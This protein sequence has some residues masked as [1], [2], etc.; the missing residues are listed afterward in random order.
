[1]SEKSSSPVSEAMSLIWAKSSPMHPLYCHLID[2]GWVSHE[3][4]NSSAFESVVPIFARASGIEE[5]QAVMW[6]SYFSAMHDIGKCDSR[7]QLYG[8]DSLAACVSGLGLPR[9]PSPCPKGFNHS[10]LSA[11]WMIDYLKDELGWH[12]K[13]AATVSVCLRGHHGDLRAEGP[14]CEPDF[15]REAWE[16]LRRETELAVRSVFHPDLRAPAFDDHSVVGIILLGIL[17][18]SDWVASNSE[19]FLIPE[20]SSDLEAYAKLSLS[21]AR[22][23]VRKLGFHI[24]EPV[25]FG[26]FFADVWPKLKEP[27]PIQTEIERLH[28]SGVLSQPGLVIIE[29]PMGEG[30]TEA[31]LYL[32]LQWIRSGN[33]GGLYVALP[34][35]ATS[36]QMYRR[37]NELLQSLGLVREQGVKLV[38]GMSWLIDDETAE[39]RPKLENVPKGEADH[40]AAW[41][42]PRKRALLASYGVGTVDQAMGGVLHVKHSYLKLF[43]LAG[44]VLIVDEIHAYDAYMSEIIERLLCWCGAIGIPVVLLSA[45]LPSAKRFSLIQS[46]GAHAPPSKTDTNAPYPLITYVSRDGVCTEHAVPKSSRSSNP[47]LIK[48][49]GALEQPKNTA[50]LVL[51][52]LED[53]GC[54]C[55]IANTVGFAQKIYDE[56]KRGLE[57]RNDCELDLFHARFPAWRRQ[58]IEDKVTSMFGKGSLL[59]RGDPSWTERPDCAILVAT[60]VVEQSLDLD[61]DEMFTEIA[62]AD[63]LLQRIGRLHRHERFCR[64]TGLRARCHLLLPDAADALEFGASRYVYHPFLLLK[65]LSVLISRDS[66]FLPD[67]IRPLVELVYDGLCCLHCPVSRVDAERVHDLWQELEKRLRLEPCKADRYL[68]PHP[69]KDDF[70]LARIAT[71]SFD[72][73]EGDAQ[74][75]FGPRTRDGDESHQLLVLEGDDFAEEMMAGSAPARDVLKE[76][77]K[78]GVDVPKWWLQGVSAAE[79]YVEI[80]KAPE[81]LPGMWVL[82]TR[83]G[84]WR[85]LNARGDEFAIANDNERGLIRTEGR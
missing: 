59:S 43:G 47:E 71:G 73:D 37:V 75:Y 29:A 72:T 32:A 65:T 26:P 68:V 84:V 36:N 27:W 56:L 40:A 77:V 78:H 53:G 76:I 24:P 25:R 38:H 13:E 42:R 46:Y 80:A 15:V 17:T 49:W 23:A 34:T 11:S 82:R 44:K 21:R 19:I 81:W 60:Q 83:D 55:I 28:N 2:V 54:F 66:V 70:M 1:M 51:S 69:S 7:F 12:R 57:G 31:A 5:L 79:D 8:P 52:R 10:A 63:L 61:F 58:E 45:T 3:L 6:L 33:A 22:A 35:T 50:D 9:A 62:P 39:G 14:V 64:P 41:F 16:P 67:D 18:W 30:K 20:A 48:H 4:L 85:G 74:S